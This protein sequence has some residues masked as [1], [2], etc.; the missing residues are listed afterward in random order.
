MAVGASGYAALGT[1]SAHLLPVLIPAGPFPVLVRLVDDEAVVGVLEVV[2]GDVGA[3]LLGLG[4]GD[5]DVLR[6][7]RGDGR[8]LLLLLPLTV[9]Y[10]NLRS[11]K[12]RREI[13]Q[14]GR[15]PA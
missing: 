12:E 2:L 3:L 1:A 7:R 15:A 14:G 6:R 8:S 4:L 9:E 13:M 11:W 10:W 5:V